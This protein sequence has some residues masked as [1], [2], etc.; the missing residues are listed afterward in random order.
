MKKDKNKI[1]KKE[2]RKNK[3]NCE[4]VKNVNVMTLDINEECVHIGC[5]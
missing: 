5:E 4:K 1:R 3:T 2:R